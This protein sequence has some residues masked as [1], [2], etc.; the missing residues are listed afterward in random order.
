MSSISTSQQ[1]Q[2]LSCALHIGRLQRAVPPAPRVDRLIADPVFL[3]DL[4]DRLLIGLTE[5]R[6]TLLRGDPRL[7]H[8]SLV[9]RGR[10]SLALQ[11]VQK[12]PGGSGALAFPCG[13]SAGEPSRWNTL[14]AL[15]V[16]RWY[17]RTRVE[18]T[19]PLRT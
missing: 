4:C 5:D 6:A 2:D 10:H 12:S 3:R 18:A 16:L 7:P 19:S 8:H 1:M 11:L 13:E 14:G 15:R 17:T 9:V